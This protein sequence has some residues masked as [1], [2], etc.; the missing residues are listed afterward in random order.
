VPSGFAAGWLRSDL[1]P[2]NT[3]LPVIS[4]AIAS[5]HTLATTNGTWSM[6]PSSYAYQW[7]RNGVAISGATASTYAL[8]SA[9]IGT[10]ITVAVIGTNSIGSTTVVSMGVGPIWTNAVAWLPSQLTTL[11]VWLKGD[12][13]T[14]ATGDPVG[15]WPDASGAGNNATVTG[16]NRPLLQ[17]AH[18]NGLNVLN[19]VASSQN[20]YNLP[21]A[22]GAFTEA[23]QIFVLKLKNSPGAN[24][25]VDGP[26]SRLGSHSGNSHYGW[27][28]DGLVYDAFA[29]TVRLSTGYNPGAA[30]HVGGMRSKAADWRYYTNGTLRYSTTTNAV[31]WLSAPTIGVSQI[32]TFNYIDCYYAEY[33]LLNEFASTADWQKLEGYL[34]NKWGTQG[35]L[36]SAHP[37]KV[38]PPYIYS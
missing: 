1:A 11:K 31:G 25:T 36:P 9:D 35:D 5:G 19:F 21:N 28:G 4:G 8:V 18:Q 13:L 14:G 2:V 34:A 7:R 12:T 20:Y 23:A 15:T 6:V 37:Y 3:V 16:T 30:Y 38:N 17:L 26:P 22:F 24:A 10:M 33:I 29:T 32:A 27:N